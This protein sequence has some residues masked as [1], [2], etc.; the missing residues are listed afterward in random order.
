[1]IIKYSFKFKTN[2]IFLMDVLT[3]IILGALQGL[4]E[5][6]PVSSQG[7]LTI[8][9]TLI[10]ESASTALDYALFLHAGTM[11]AALVYYRKEFKEMLTKGVLFKF[12]FITTLVSGALG[13][14]LYFAVKGLSESIGAG[15]IAV[16]GAA[17]IVTGALQLK[18]KKSG[19]RKEPTTKDA[20]IT[21]LAQGFSIIPGISRS[22]TTTSTLLFS[23]FNGLT[24]LKLSFILSVP[25]V[26][27]AD[28]G[29]GLLES[30]VITWD[31]ALGLVAS[32]IVGL[33]SIKLL[34][35][36]AKRV[37]FGKLCIAMGA[38]MMLSLLTI[39]T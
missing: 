28:I 26:L 21:G 9:M 32:F 15:L 36:V 22:G 12:V 13:G 6:L 24:A 33:A 1:L 17:L 34:M 38:I 8:I 20:V 16:V 27:V 11:M 3:I 30:P 10:G 5:W 29:L 23:G 2:K 37:N 4:L 7:M 18:K 39:I 14:A 31:G 35:N 19:L 25:V